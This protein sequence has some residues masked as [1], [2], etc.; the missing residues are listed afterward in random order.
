M[1]DPVAG[2]DPSRGEAAHPAGSAFVVAATHSGAGKTTATAVL[3][4]RLCERGLRVRAFKIGPDFIDPGYHREITGRP[5]I[6]LDLWMMGPDGI[7]RTFTRWA[8]GAEVCVI[9][10][11]GGLY[12]GENG[13]E[14]GSAAHVAKL[15]GLPVVVVVDVWGMTRT[16]AA[17]LGGLRS[18]DPELRIAGFVLNRAGSATHAEMV[19]DALPDEL[20]RLALGH[21]P[22]RE[23]LRVTERHLGLM[24]VE[25]NAT[26]AGERAAAQLSAGDALDIDRLLALT[27][28]RLPAAE[29]G[30]RPAPAPA[31]ARLAVARDAAFCFYYEENLRAL[32]EAGFELVEF[33]PTVDKQLP[34]GADAVYLGGGYPESFAAELGANDRLAAELRDRAAG[35][36]PM[37]AECGGMMFLARS[38]TGFD[39]V[40][41]PMAGV[42]PI[43][44][45]MD[46]DYLAIKYVEVRTR[47]RSPFGPA[48]VRVRGQEFHQ[49]RITAEG[50]EPD[51]F[52]V[53]TSTGATHRAGYLRH[54]VLASY[55]HLYFAADSDLLRNFLHLATR[56]RAGSS[57]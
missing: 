46:R 20:R 55:L 16:A 15:L 41:A 3:L 5:S 48:G 24:T 13:T 1:T 21:L 22:R 39:G 43:D 37:L 32:A 56:Y 7:R 54:N 28:T 27:R 53:T 33:A 49:S 26:G 31:R 57:A 14:T 2:S 38:L 23:E 8:A 45:V 42:L 4:R 29:G 17:I 9:E 44:V 19:L 12:D 50:L 25:E 10:A 6:N 36:M 51:L 52:E 40:R 35:G 34:E 47:T 18:F 30:A 11:M